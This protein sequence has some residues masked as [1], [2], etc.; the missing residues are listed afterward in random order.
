[1]NR[2]LENHCLFCRLAIHILCKAIPSII[3]FPRSRLH[4][5]LKEFKENESI[6]IEDLN[7]HWWVLVGSGCHV[8]IQL[9][10]VTEYG[11]H[12]HNLLLTAGWWVPI[13]SHLSAP[14]SLA[15]NLLFLGLSDPRNWFVWVSLGIITGGVL[16]DIFTIPQKLVLSSAGPYLFSS[17]MC[18]SQHL[19]FSTNR[20]WFQAHWSA[21]NSQ[22]FL[23][24][25]MLMWEDPHS[26]GGWT[27]SL[28]WIYPHFTQLFLIFGCPSKYW[29]EKDS[30]SLGGWTFSL[31]WIYHHFS[32]CTLKH[33]TSIQYVLTLS[34]VGR[35]Y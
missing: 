15:W 31:Q 11:E 20:I 19:S 16:L 35:L 21:I 7:Q 34:V 27:I 23:S 1:L 14:W 25:Q 17:N 22:F 28:Q 5:Q 32:V 26:L 12:K 13:L 3:C 6:F 33:T 4:S 8:Q 24:Q 10:Y 2:S 30:H 9:H 29:F 18:G